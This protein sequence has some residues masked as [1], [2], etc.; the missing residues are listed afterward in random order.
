MVADRLFHKGKAIDSRGGRR[1]LCPQYRICII[2]HVANNFL[3]SF[4]LLIKTETNGSAKTLMHLVQVCHRGDAVTGKSRTGLR[5]LRYHSHSGTSTQS[6]VV[7]RCERSFR[8]HGS[9]Q[10]SRDVALFV[11][12]CVGCR[13]SACN[14]AVS[15]RIHDRRSPASQDGC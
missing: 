3:F 12:S 10:P 15:S 5:L 11:A 14:R 13:R 8:L 6:V 2:G 4:N 7:D 9:V 1:L